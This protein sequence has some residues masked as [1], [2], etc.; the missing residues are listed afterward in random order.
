[1]YSPEGS[2][3]M[4]LIFLKTSLNMWVTATGTVERRRSMTAA[5]IARVSS[6]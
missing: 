1:M 3:N 2:M 4:A 6:P 5:G